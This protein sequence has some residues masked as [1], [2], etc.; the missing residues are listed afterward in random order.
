MPS[1]YAD[2]AH[3]SAKALSDQR[4][5]VGHDNRS[6]F[7]IEKIRRRNLRRIFYI[8]VRPLIIFHSRIAVSTATELTRNVHTHQSIQTSQT[9][10][11]NASPSSK[12][13]SGLPPTL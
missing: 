7:H 3:I 10:H 6:D 13:V 8:A 2:H 5:Q 1:P 11:P 9:K 12:V 4:V